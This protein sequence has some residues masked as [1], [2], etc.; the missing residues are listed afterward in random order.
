MCV[1][2]NVNSYST[3]I[4]II[5]IN[6]TQRKKIYKEKTKVKK[7]HNWIHFTRPEKNILYV[8]NYP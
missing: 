7:K 8:V 5:R 1:P 2:D 3:G 6:F 4:L